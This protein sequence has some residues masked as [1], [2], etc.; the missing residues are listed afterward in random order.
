MN[1]TGIKIF[2]AL[3]LC[4]AL[5]GLGFWV[6]QG[7]AQRQALKDKNAALSA[8]KEAILADQKTYE[9]NIRQQMQAFAASINQLNE[10]RDAINEKY[11]KSLAADRAGTGG[12]R[13]PASVCSNS[14][15]AVDE[16][17]S[18]ADK[19][20]ARTIALP[21]RVTEDLRRLAREADEVMAQCRAIQSFSK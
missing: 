4:A 7:M 14:V 9:E 10:E 6:G 3:T 19:T 16:T 17:T 18:R 11:Q 1:S 8:Q 20:S 2:A 21:E 15:P 12:L 5:L 13:L